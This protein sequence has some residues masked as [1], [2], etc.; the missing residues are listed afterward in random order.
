MATV[1]LLHDYAESV[2]RHADLNE[3]NIFV[4]RRDPT[5][6]TSIIDWQFVTARPL[7]LQARWPLF[8]EPPLGYE[9]GP[10][11]P[12]MP[13]LT[14]GHAAAMASFQRALRSKMYESALATQHERAYDALTEI[15]DE[16]RDLFTRP[17]LTYSNGVVP[18]RQTLMIL[19][20]TWKRSDHFTEPCPVTFTPAEE[21]ALDEASKQY[22]ERQ[23]DPMNIV[24]FEND[25][26]WPDGEREGQ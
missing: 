11:Q 9:I 18:L 26:S 14:P 19:A 8:L 23:E 24:S 20:R 13:A 6:V 5:T 21:Y 2:L 1:P 7:F 25:L 12:E 15:N 22:I 17:E 10:V 16:F 3:G 4:A